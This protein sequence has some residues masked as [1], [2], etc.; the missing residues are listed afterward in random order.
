MFLSG[1]KA[2]ET[3]DICRLFSAKFA[4]VF[5]E[6]QV[7]ADRASSAAT[8]V[9]LYGQSLSSIDVDNTSIINAARR[10]KQAYN[11]GPDGI[12]SLFF[13]KRY[14]ENLL[15]PLQH[16]FQLSLF[17]HAGNMRMCFLC[18][19]K[20][21]ATM[22]IT[23]VAQPCYVRSPNCSSLLYWNAYYRIASNT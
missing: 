23:I 17:S 11:A 14:L 8:N 12:P 5:V 18:I 6:E 7:S 15:L 19:R 21:I 1:E 13:F 9:S 4:S 2:T 20:E 16:L 10:L 3:K 22:L